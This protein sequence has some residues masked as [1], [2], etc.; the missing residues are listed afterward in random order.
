MCQAKRRKDPLNPDQAPG[1]SVSDDDFAV[2]V[3]DHG[4]KS[5]SE[6]ILD[7]P[8][9]PPLLPQPEKPPVLQ[10]SGHNETTGTTATTADQK[11]AALALWQRRS[12]EK[13]ER[14]DGD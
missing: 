5:L 10:A 3:G 11:R 4:G 7:T 2:D 6:I 8:P 12:L 1:G 13:A 14:V 9:V